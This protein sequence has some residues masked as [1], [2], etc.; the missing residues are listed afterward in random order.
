MM[1]AQFVETQL[2]M[3]TTTFRYTFALCAI[4]GSRR[5]PPSKMEA[6]VRSEMVYLTKAGA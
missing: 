3:L 6:A 5:R 4:I 1:R 2:E